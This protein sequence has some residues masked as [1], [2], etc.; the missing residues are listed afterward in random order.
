M[1]IAIQFGESYF[2]GS[3]PG[4]FLTCE[5]SVSARDEC[6][7][8][9]LPKAEKQAFQSAAILENYL[10]HFGIS[11]EAI[12]STIIDRFSNDLPWLRTLRN[13]QMSFRLGNIS[14]Q[15]IQLV[16]AYLTYSLE[17]IDSLHNKLSVAHLIANIDGH[18]RIREYWTS[19]PK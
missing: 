17:C 11:V 9:L 8:V 7:L 15:S 19:P 12:D 3:R 14:T 10:L 16:M 4:L 13:N 5:S 1:K 2:N 6:F 18:P